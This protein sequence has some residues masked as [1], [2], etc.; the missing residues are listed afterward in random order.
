LPSYTRFGGEVLLQLNYIIWLPDRPPNGWIDIYAGKFDGLIWRVTLRMDGKPLAFDSI[1][2]C[3]CYY[4]IFPGAGVRVAQPEDG[5]E[6]IFS[7]MPILGP[8]P[9]ERVLVR[10]ASSTHFIQ[11]VASEKPSPDA[12][13]YGWL[14]YDQLRSLPMPSGLNRSMFDSDGLVRCSQRP[15]RFLLWPMGVPSAGAMRQWG[16]HAIAF[17]GKRHFDD[18]WL[19]RELLRPVSE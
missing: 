15:E 10:L 6:P 18:P 12:K 19:M 1:H 14:D 5:S 11:A 16:T 7:P 2:S 3:G 8:N 13:H 4:Q 17:L 9:G